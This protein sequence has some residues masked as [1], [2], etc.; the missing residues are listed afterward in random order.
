MNRRNLLK[1]PI[2]AFLFKSLPKRMLKKESS[3]EKLESSVRYLK[4]R[5]EQILE[6]LGLTHY[7]IVDS[8]EDSGEVVS[9]W[10]RYIG[11][12]RWKT[13]AIFCQDTDKLWRELTDVDPKARYTTAWIIK[14]KS[15]SICSITMP[16][17]INNHLQ[18]FETG[19]ISMVTKQELEAQIRG[20]EAQLRDVPKQVEQI[21]EAIRM[22][23]KAIS[24]IEAK[25]ERED[26]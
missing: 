25:E 13:E 14:Q 9:R 17:S 3:E 19:D 5:S 10:L 24:E 8:Y 20:H 6:A 22:K 12:S 15:W 23:K 1:I 16:T 26:T 21:K 7:I 18:Q 11:N 4:T 2:I